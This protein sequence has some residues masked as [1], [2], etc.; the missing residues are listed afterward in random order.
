M[1][2]TPANKVQFGLK[3]VHYAVV[4]ETPNQTTGALETT[5]GT[6]KAWPGAV[7]MTMTASGEQSKFFAD[8]T[9]YYT[10][11][12]NAGYDVEFECAAI[13][14]D[15]KT[16]VLG[17]S[18]DTKGVI[19]ET[20]DDTLHYIAL[21]F[22]FNGDQGA[23]KHILYR[24]MLSRPT[25][26]GSTTEDSTTVQTLSLNLTASARVDADHKIHAEIGPDGDATVYTG[27]YDTVYVAAS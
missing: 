14:E 23:A 22:E 11:S 5:Y 7:K 1:P 10:A 27:W 25:R 15:V 9:A 21:L 3:N 20:S 12:T 2:S 17:Q 26:E 16:S 18:K 24:C 6:V 8:D 13:P 19:F 4:T